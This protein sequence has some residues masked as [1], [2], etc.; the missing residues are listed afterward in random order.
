[1]CQKIRIATHHRRDDNFVLIART[2][3][4]SV[5]GF[6]Q[7]VARAKAYVEA[8]ADAIFPEA[9][10]DKEEF[11]AFAKAVKVP[12]LANMT[13]FGKS[14]LLS[15]KEL[16]QMGYKMIIFPVSTLRIAMKATENF[17]RDLKAEGTQKDMLERMQTRQELYDLIE[18]DKYA[19]LD[20]TVANYQI[21]Q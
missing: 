13:E 2:D 5:E 16:Q 12:L 9:L 10:K 19:E 11:E 4:R 7:A 18:Y 3:A 1:M 6:D 21:T 20:Q 14:P 17:L 15:V 8:G